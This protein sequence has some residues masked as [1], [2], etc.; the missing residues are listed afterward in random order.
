[1]TKKQRKHEIREIVKLVDQVAALSHHQMAKVQ[2]IRVVLARF[3]R[4]SEK[5]EAS[6]GTA[7]ASRT[8]GS[9]GPALLSKQ[10]P[11]GDRLL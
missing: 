10:H 6:E 7:K 9:L 5:V 4:S 11:S 1:M 2:G 3:E 8:M